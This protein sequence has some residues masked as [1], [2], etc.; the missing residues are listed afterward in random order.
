MSNSSR[1]ARPATAKE[2]LH[3]TEVVFSAV[4]HPNRRQIL[5]VLHFRGGEMTA[6]EIA[7]RFSCRWPTTTRHLKVLEAAGLVQVVPRGRERL[8]RLNRKRLIA[9]MGSWLEWFEKEAAIGPPS[10]TV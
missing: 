5:M 7:E 10:R 4:A 2:R 6:G 1:S 3:D 8:Y 9:T